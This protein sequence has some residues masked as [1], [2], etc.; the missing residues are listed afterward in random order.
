MRTFLILL[1]LCLA[2]GRAEKG[3]LCKSL[4]TCVHCKLSS[5]YT[6]LQS[7]Y[8]EACLSCNHT[9]FRKIR[10]FPLE[11]YDSNED[12]GFDPRTSNIE[13]KVECSTIDD[14]GCLRVFWY[15]N[16]KENN[17][18]QDDPGTLLVWSDKAHN[19][20]PPQQVS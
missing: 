12:I 16:H 10:I 18:N 5:P 4:S 17:A 6:G 2:K 20:C 19:C 8:S 7:Y 11:E 13:E 14:S 1:S 15:T 3:S 9:V